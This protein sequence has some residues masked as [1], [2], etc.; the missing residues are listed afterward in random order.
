MNGYT[1]SG[2]GIGGA[3]QSYVTAAAPFDLSTKTAYQGMSDTSWWLIYNDTYLG[4]LITQFPEGIAALPAIATSAFIIS[5]TS[6]TPPPTGWSVAVQGEPPPPTVLPWSTDEDSDLDESSESSPSSESSLSSD[7]SS[8]TSESSSSSSTQESLT[9]SGTSDSSTSE[10]S[11]SSSSDI[12]IYT[13]TPPGSGSKS[14]VRLGD[15]GSGHAC[16]PPRANISASINV[17][18]NGLGAHR[19]GD[20]W[21]IHCCKGHCHRGVLQSGS[22]TVFVNGKQLGRVGDPISCGSRCATGS[23]NVFA[24]D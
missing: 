1:V 21:E 13:P 10:S 2:S 23:P 7:S 24:G 6:D 8:Q 14:V 18:V 22:S 17:F 11:S 16:W 5:S 20:N 3:N 9:S 19:Q 15:T 12:P 4:W